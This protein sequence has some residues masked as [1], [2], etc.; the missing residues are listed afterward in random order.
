MKRYYTNEE[1]K[2]IQR[3][4][5]IYSWKE[6][7][8]ILDRHPDSVRRRAK[9]LSLEKPQPVY[10]VYRGDKFIWKGTA[11]ECADAANVK[12]Q[13]IIR[14]ACPYERFKILQQKSN[15]NALFVYRVEDEKI[16]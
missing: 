3:T 4:Y 9:M 5:N 14:N 13:H 11:E 16:G 8:H 7:G 12:K 1:D 15:S 10:E 2:I 6:I